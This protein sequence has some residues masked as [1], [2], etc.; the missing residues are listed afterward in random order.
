[1]P[2]GH[3]GGGF[4]VVKDF[5]IVGVGSQFRSS[6]ILDPHDGAIRIDADGNGGKLIRGLKHALDDDGGV[7]TLTFHCRRPAELAGRDLHVVRPE[8]P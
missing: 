7:Q 6:H 8:A 5:D 1:M 3:A 2:D 4:T